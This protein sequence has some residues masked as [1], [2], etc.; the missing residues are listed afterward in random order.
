MA[1]RNT[2]GLQFIS[3]AILACAVAPSSA[4]AWGPEGH[5]IVAAVAEKNL[6]KKTKSQ[7]AKLLEPDTTLADAANYADA[8]R[9]RCKNTGS[10]H[11]VDIPLKAAS[12]DAARDCADQ[13]GGCVLAA[14]DRQIAILKDRTQ[15]AE[16]REFALKF[17]VHFVG[18]LHQPL[19]SS[20]NQDRGGNEVQV[21]FEGKKSNL[22][23]LW[24]SGLIA[25]K[26]LSEE[27][28]VRVLLGSVSRS[29]KKTIQQGT[30]TEWALEAHK[31]AQDFA[32]GKLG[33]EPSKTKIIDL[34]GDYTD[35]VI[36][37]LDGQLLRAGL[38]LAKVLNDTFASAGPKVGSD[39][40]AAN[41]VCSTQ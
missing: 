30:A 38:R 15:S 3:A 29:E 41:H 10:W 18:D 4:F 26:G 23:K 27:S 19:H 1:T 13:K 36:D 28:Y 33:T 7:I 16:D 34:S 9:A 8:Y 39:L 14:L 22:H 25:T 40:V 31:A 2:T 6:T 21:R 32:Y 5:R 17:I 24:D 35:A 12:Y 37:T 20:D 11:F